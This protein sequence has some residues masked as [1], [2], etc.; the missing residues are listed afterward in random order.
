MEDI[1][2]VI[3]VMI[4]WDQTA[5]ELSQSEAF[6]STSDLAMVYEYSCL[7]SQGI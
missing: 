2:A 7:H 6:A 1:L 5:V 4:N 3:G